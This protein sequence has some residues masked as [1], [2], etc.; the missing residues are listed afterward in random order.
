MDNQEERVVPRNGSKYTQTAMEWSGANNYSHTRPSTS[1][2]LWK[3]IERSFPS[4]NV[5]RVHNGFCWWILKTNIVSE[6]RKESNS[7]D[8]KEP[9][10][11]MRGEI[12]FPS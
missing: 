12:G 10:N 4:D 8:S 2:Q 7:K 1:L 6:D 9:S 5:P 3:D 11:W